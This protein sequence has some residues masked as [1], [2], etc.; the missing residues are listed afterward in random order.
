MAGAAAG[1]E[2]VALSS[3]NSHDQSS[4]D[5]HEEYFCCR[6]NGRDFGP[7]ACDPHC[8]CV[9]N[10]KILSCSRGRSAG[11]QLLH[12][13][14]RNTEQIRIISCPTHELHAQREIIDFQQRDADG[15]KAEISPKKIE[16]R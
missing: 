1:A 9:H 3:T 2:R 5:G 4:R 14:A 11:S 16:K 12:H 10:H 7:F 8:A 6:T 13:E 15:W